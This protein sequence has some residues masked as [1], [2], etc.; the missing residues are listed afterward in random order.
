MI[1]NNYVDPLCKLSS[2]FEPNLTITSILLR[3]LLAVI[4]GFLIGFERASKNHAAGI[5]TYILV[6]LG[7]TCAMLTNIYLVATYNVGDTARFGASV[8]SGIGFL[9]AGSIMITSRS[10]IKG[11]TTAA[12][13]W[14]SA[15]T[16]LA[17][18]AA[19][20][21]LALIA[22]FIVII[23]FTI[24]HK[25]ESV[26][27]HYSRHFSIHVEFLSPTYLKEFMEKLRSDKISIERTEKNDSFVDSGLNVYTFFLKRNG[28]IQISNKEYIE[29]ISKLDY[30]HFCEEIR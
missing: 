29:K 8:L 7:A 6:T 18:G 5:R 11:L 16:G 17:I 15:C 23:S 13:L 14:T 2:I 10:Q 28:K 27:R 24:L 20:Y 30:V 4:I 26:L 19:F 25:F 1:I 12:G 9:G 21:T 3:I 22:S